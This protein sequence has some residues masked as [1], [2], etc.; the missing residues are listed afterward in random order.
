[1][2]ARRPWLRFSLRTLLILITAISIWLGLRVNAA[3]RQARAVAEIK[4]RPV[5]SVRYDFE[6]KAKA[7]E[8]P[9]SW[10][11]QWILA[12]TGPDLFHNVVEAHFD[13]VNIPETMSGDEVVA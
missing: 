10:M 1:M 11:P 3:R 5:A 7:G 9:T 12:R 6:T 2:S 8:K 4:S 13:E